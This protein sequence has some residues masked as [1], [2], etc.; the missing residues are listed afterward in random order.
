M[1]WTIVITTIINWLVVLVAYYWDK[2]QRS[3]R[4][5]KQL[6]TENNTMDTWIKSRTASDQQL[7]LQ[8]SY[9]RGLYDG[10]QT[11]TLYRQ[12]LKKFQN[13]DQVELIINGIESVPAE[14]KRRSGREG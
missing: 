13:G 12:M 8:R 9:D 6:R 14:R 1:F 2:L 5:I 4:E 3:K 7:E 11:D 10:R